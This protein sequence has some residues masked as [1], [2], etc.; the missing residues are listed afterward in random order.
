MK[1]NSNSRNPFRLGKAAHIRLGRAGEKYAA[2]VL[3]SK[4]FAIICRNW[5]AGKGELDIVARDGFMLVFVEVKSRRF[6]PAGSNP[7]ANLRPR[8]IARIRYGAEK[9][10]WKIFADKDIP[11]R[12]DLVEVWIDNR[13]PVKIFHHQQCFRSAKPR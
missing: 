2:E 4:G 8:Q 3:R 9:Y 10:L 6:N 7:R 13:R 11:H 5:R 1:I 12:F